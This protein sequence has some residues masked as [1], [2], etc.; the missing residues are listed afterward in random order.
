MA[1]DSILLLRFNYLKAIISVVILSTSVV[2]LLLLKY[3]VKLR[4]NAFYTILER[5]K[6]AKATHV[7]LGSTESSS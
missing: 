7:F 4:V 6:A 1:I 3:F 5:Q 2:G